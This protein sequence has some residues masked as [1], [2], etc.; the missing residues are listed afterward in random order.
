MG[1]VPV[2]WHR[3]RNRRSAATVRE[4]RLQLMA[5]LQLASHGKIGALSALRRLLWTHQTC[6]Q[7]F[8]PQGGAARVYASWGKE[9]LD[10]SLPSLQTAGF[11]DPAI[12]LRAARLEELA[13][14][15]EADFMELRRSVEHLFHADPGRILLRSLEANHIIIDDHGVEVDLP[16]GTAPLCRMDEQELAFILDNLIENALRAMAG[17]PTRK[18]GI[19]WERVDDQICLLVSDTGCGIIPEDWERI[20]TAGHSTRKGGGLGLTG[21]R[22]VLAK[23]GGSLTVRSSEAGQGTTMML[24]CPA[25]GNGPTI[26]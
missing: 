8:E 14:R 2:I 21:S 18:L 12:R 10:T 4:L 9:C 17:S 25:A 5:R 7:G 1:G 11:G 13:A 26:H 20:F 22:E 3:R 19:A 15:T 23:Y 24:L 6:E 16:E